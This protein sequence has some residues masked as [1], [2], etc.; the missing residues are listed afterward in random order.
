MTIDEI[1]IR[2]IG[3]NLELD[4]F[5]VIDVCLWIV[6][7]VCISTIDKKKDHT[8][9]RKRALLLHKHDASIIALL[10]RENKNLF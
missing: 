5:L 4:S 9:M 2:G 1:L 3:K 8:S 6:V 7:V 10:M